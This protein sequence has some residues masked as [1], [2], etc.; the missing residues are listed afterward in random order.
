MELLIIQCDGED[1]A[2]SNIG[3]QTWPVAPHNPFSVFSAAGRRRLR[4]HTDGR[5]APLP[6]VSL[7]RDLSPFPDFSPNEQ[8]LFRHY[9]SHIAV[10]MMPYEHARNPWRSHYPAAALCR[11]EANPLYHAML[12]QAAFNISQ[13]RGKDNVMIVTASKHYQLAIKQLQSMIFQDETSFCKLLVSMMTLL[14]VEVY[15]TLSRHLPS[16]A[17]MTRS[18]VDSRACGDI[19]FKEPGP[20]SKSILP[21]NRGKWQ[22]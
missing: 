8:S 15:V 6:V 22:M 11:T 7:P 13:L 21:R 14:F 12:A 10:I 9:V 16:H 3:Q 19:T 5:T 18:T 2:N 4:A 17:K 1:T 20:Y